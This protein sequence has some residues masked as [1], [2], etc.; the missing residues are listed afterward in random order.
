MRYRIFR[1]YLIRVAQDVIISRYRNRDLAPEDV[2]DGWFV[3]SDDTDP[4]WMVEEHEE[5]QRLFEALN[6]IPLES[7]DILE[8]HYFE[9]LSPNELA[10]VFDVPP[11]VIRRRLRQ[12]LHMLRQAFLETQDDP[13]SEVD[14]D[15]QL[16]AAG[17]Q[18]GRP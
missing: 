6:C 8:L 17:A 10:A 9:A 2:D 18:R 14:L 1:S 5:Q 7:R 11:S 16:K 3:A 4:S 15:A 13:Q 12:A